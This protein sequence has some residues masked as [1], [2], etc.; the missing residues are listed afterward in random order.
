MPPVA[1]R[2]PGKV[3]FLE[4]SLM[5]TSVFLAGWAVAVILAL[6]AFHCFWE[7]G[8]ADLDTVSRGHV[9]QVAGT[10]VQLRPGLTATA[11]RARAFLALIAASALALGVLALAH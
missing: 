7:A 2:R 4:A 3:P 1:G 6:Y 5:T 8:R 10:R 11:Y 9:L